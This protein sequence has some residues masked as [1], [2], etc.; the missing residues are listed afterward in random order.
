MKSNLRQPGAPLTRISAPYLPPYSDG[1]VRRFLTATT[2]ATVLALVPTSCMKSELRDTPAAPAEATLVIKGATL[3]DGTGSEPLPDSII[4]IK[5]G[6]FHVVSS[7]AGSKL[8]ENSNIID[9]SGK[10][11]TPGLIDAHVHFW[12]SGR[13]FTSPRKLDLTASVPYTEEVEWMKQRR[14]VTLRGYLCAGVTSALSAGGPRFEL[15]TRTLAQNSDKAPNVFLSYGPVSTVPSY[16][17]FPPVDGDDPVRTIERTSEVRGVIEGTKAW[18]ARVIKTGYLGGPFSELEENFHQI[19]KAIADAAKSE[20]MLVT[21]HAYQ[22]D[23]AKK[24]IL[25]GSDSLQHI[26]TDMPVDDEFIELAKQRG[27]IVVPTLALFRRG[28]PLRARN[29]VLEPIE[30][31]CGDPEVIA[32]WN[33]APVD[34]D[35]DIRVSDAPPQRYLTAQLNTKA[36]YSAGITIAAGSDAGNI[37]LIQGATLQY[38][39]KLLSEAGLSNADIIRAATLNSAR[40]AGVEDSVGSIEVGKIA[41]LLIL[42]GNPLDDITNMQRIDIVVKAGRAY[43]ESDLLPPQN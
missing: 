34:S 26:A 12:E 41:D 43:P 30:T 2:A 22:L 40:V 27:T 15:E 19:N 33:M 38:E 9:A 7:E 24:S 11:V 14:P 5:N 36:L 1:K 6:K 39:L 16:M 31:R 42:D 17:I 29:E 13:I 4:V 18:D 32:S 20:G 28:N 8:P 10:W 25:D 21:T 37:G 3:I 35:S 23:A